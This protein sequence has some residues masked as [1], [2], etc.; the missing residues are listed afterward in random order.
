MKRFKEHL[1]SRQSASD[2]FCRIPGDIEIKKERNLKFAE[3]SLQWYHY[4]LF[5]RKYV[6]NLSKLAYSSNYFLEVFAKMLLNTLE[7]EKENSSN[8]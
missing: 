4:C 1:F 7:Q 5:Y 6:W 2:C 3:D 8:F